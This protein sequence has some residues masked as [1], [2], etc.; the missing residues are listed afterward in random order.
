[1][2]AGT[3]GRTNSHSGGGLNMVEYR[4]VTVPVRDGKFQ[5]QL[6]EGGTGENLIFLHGEDGFTERTPFLDQL[7]QHFH[8]Y[9]PVHPGQG[10]SN[11]LEHLDDLWDLMVFYEELMQQLGI[12]R[13]H[14]IGHSYGGML[15]AELAAHR[16]EMVSRLVLIDSLGLWLDDSPISDFF[17][18][19]AEERAK[20]MWFDSECDAARAAFTEPTDPEEKMETELARTTTLAAVGKFIWPIPDRGL[21]KRI[22]RITMPAL[23]VWGDSDGMVSMK[24]AHAFQSLLPNSSLK[25]IEKSGHLPHEE[26]PSE[27]LEAILPFL[28]E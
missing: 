21:T 12:D 14:A 28:G 11:G 2:V 5:V 1:M 19:T 22:H 8:V 23:L 17:V 10:G 25:V 20:T 9:A 13:A 16:P 26:R 18:L 7:A 6:A 27:V 3:R 15:A 4:H 24:Y